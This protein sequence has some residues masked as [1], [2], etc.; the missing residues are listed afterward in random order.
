MAG[1]MATT[2]TGCIEAVDNGS[3]WQL[4]HLTD[5]HEKGM[6]D[7][8]MAAKDDGMAMKKDDGMA[9]EKDAGPMMNGKNV[10]PKQVALSG[11]TDLKKHVG[12]KVTVTGSLSAEFTGPMQSEVRTL[13]V[14]S[15]KVVAK[16]CVE[17]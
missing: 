2:Y 14:S 1:K 6:K 16:S 17:K 7:H 15:L 12:Q 5:D 13:T 3:A 11:S 4:T 8:G 9:R 10:L